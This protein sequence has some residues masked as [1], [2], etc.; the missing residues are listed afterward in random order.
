MD[1]ARGWLGLFVFCVG[2]V[3]FMLFSKNSTIALF[4]IGAGIG[5]MTSG[6]K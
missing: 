3:M 1:N 5:M 2:V 6:F 4:C